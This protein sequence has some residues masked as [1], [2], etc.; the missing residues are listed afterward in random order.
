[1]EATISQDKGQRKLGALLIAASA[2]VWPISSSLSVLIEWNSWAEAIVRNMLV[3]VF[4]LIGIA[5][6][7]WPKFRFTVQA[8]FVACMVGLSNILFL[9]GVEYSS[10]SNGVLL[11][12]TFPAIS[13][14]LDC[15]LGRR[16]PQRLEM[17]LTI[18]ALEG[19]YLV[20]GWNS[21]AA[22]WLG[23]L[24]SV[25]AALSWALA[26]HFGG[27]TMSIQEMLSCT[28]HGNLWVGVAALPVLFW[29]AP[30]PLPLSDVDGLLSVGLITSIAFVPLCLG[31]GKIEPHL[32]ALIQLIEIPEALLLGHLANGEIITSSKIAGAMLILC[33]AALAAFMPMK[34]KTTR[35]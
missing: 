13:L 18:L 32:G 30:P 22:H 23:G 16:W 28:A 1:M 12:S 3:G 33:A 5:W 20:M 34:E 10:V 7:R 24:F 27:K 29:A 4:L 6:R 31:V 15:L 25:G 21:G 2:I 11:Y 17:L 8:V 14:S 26:L 19:A 35:S 9:A